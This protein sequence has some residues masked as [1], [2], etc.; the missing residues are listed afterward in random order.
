MG[1]ASITIFLLL[2]CYCLALSSFH[3][4]LERN[5]L[6]QGLYYFTLVQRR[7]LN[8]Y[9]F[10][11]WTRFCVRDERTCLSFISVSF[12]FSFH[13]N[14]FVVCYNNT[15][16]YCLPVYGITNLFNIETMW[17]TRV[18]LAQS[19]ITFSCSDRNVCVFECAHVHFSPSLF[20]IRSAFKIVVGY[21]LLYWL[22]F[23]W[24]NNICFFY[25]APLIYQVSSI[26]MR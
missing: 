22:I 16:R 17:I 11:R 13:F 15:A 12:F 20:L 3:L 2:L 4:A 10:I 21:V 25:F 6:S 19:P 23:V 18:S 8:S 5:G 1:K 9:R 24:Q 7:M 14:S 26:R